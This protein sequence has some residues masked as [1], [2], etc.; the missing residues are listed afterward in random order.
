MNCDRIQNRLTSLPDP[1]SV[2]PKLRAHVQ[3]CAHCRNWLAGLCRLDEQLTRL[4]V[5]E[6]DPA[7]RIEFG[8]RFEEEEVSPPPALAA[9]RRGNPFWSRWSIGVA[10]AAAVVVACVALYQY[11]P[12][13]DARPVAEAQED[14]MLARMMDRHVQLSVANTP[15]EKVEQLAQLAGDLRDESRALA[16][17]ADKEDLDALANHYVSIVQQ[18]VLVQAREMASRDRGMLAGIAEDL[19]QTGRDFQRLAES[20]PPAALDSIR[21]I[22]QTATEGDL[23]LRTLLPGD[24]S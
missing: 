11:W 20:V 9:H 10:A 5:P 14:P 3:S 7:I 22:A 17:V 4:P 13:P 1:R 24:V 19:R 2:P 15:A 8:R 18:G 23:H 12:P 21:K 16:R 6:S